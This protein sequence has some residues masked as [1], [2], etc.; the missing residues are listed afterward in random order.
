METDRVIKEGDIILYII[1]KC[2]AVVWYRVILLP[3][4]IRV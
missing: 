2:N 1:K 3:V 4:R